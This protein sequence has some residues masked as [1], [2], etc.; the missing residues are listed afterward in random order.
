MLCFFVV[1]LWAIEPTYFPGDEVRFATLSN[2]SSN[3]VFGCWVSLSVEDWPLLMKMIDAG[4]EQA[5]F[6][7]QRE[8]RMFKIQP[9]A[10]GVVEEDTGESWVRMR[11]YY[12]GIDSRSAKNACKEDEKGQ[13]YLV[14]YVQKSAL[15]LPDVI[16]V[17]A[18]LSITPDKAF[19]PGDLVRTKY[20]S[21]P[22]DS[23]LDGYACSSESNFLKMAKWIEEGNKPALEMFQESQQ[24]AWV[25]PGSFGEVIQH[26][27]RAGWC[28]VALEPDIAKPPLKNCMHLRPDGGRTLHMYLKWTTLEKLSAEEETRSPIFVSPPPPSVSE[29]PIFDVGE[30]VDL[31]M[32]FAP[33][34]FEDVWWGCQSLNDWELMMECIEAKDSQALSALER[35]NRAIRVMSSLNC[36]VV[37][38]VGKDW[39]KIRLYGSF[40]DTPFY[41]K[42]SNQDE[43]GQLYVVTYIQREALKRDP[44]S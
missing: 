32:G 26:H 42:V 43:D 36:L 7:L 14:V 38:D 24:G 10:P 31:Q 12:H 23:Y 3:K 27:P 33:S 41:E 2:E 20:T 17:I 5:L 44:L 8:G 21:I 34:R 28:L 16:D 15:Q 25:P 37:E 18:S 39:V 4:D 13:K 6:A 19:S 1:T 22:A 35:E 40:I 11:Y 9:T 30:S 29:K